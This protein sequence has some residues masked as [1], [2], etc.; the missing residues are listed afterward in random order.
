MRGN[1]RAF[2]SVI[3]PCKLDGFILQEVLRIEVWVLGL[4]CRNIEAEWDPGRDRHPMGGPGIHPVTEIGEDTFE[5][6]VVSVGGVVI[7]RFLDFGLGH[8]F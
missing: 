5:V 3:D 7:D 4:E 6:I 2:S 1:Y 8:R